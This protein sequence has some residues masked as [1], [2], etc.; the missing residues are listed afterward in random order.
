MMG[1]VRFL[2]AVAEGHATA[3]TTLSASCGTKNRLEIVSFRQGKGNIV[4]EQFRL[5]AG[6]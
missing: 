5:A 4:G 6:E 3:A 2:P 1:Y